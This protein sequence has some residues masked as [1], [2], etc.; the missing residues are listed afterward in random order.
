MV[1]EREVR[2]SESRVQTSGH[3]AL[4]PLRGTLPLWASLG[5]AG[6]QLRDALSHPTQPNGV[7][8]EAFGM[9]TDDECAME[10]LGPDPEADPI[11]L[12]SRFKG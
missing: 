8:V 1:A 2:V 10:G 5:L 9:L 4:P 3:A 7:G 11:A 6:P 12:I